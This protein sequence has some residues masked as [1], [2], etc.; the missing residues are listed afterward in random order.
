M[1][2]LNVEDAYCNIAVYPTHRFLLGMKWYGLYYVELVLPVNFNAVFEAVKWILLNCYMY[3]VSDLLH[4]LDDFIT[5][6]PP[7][8]PQCAQNLSTSLEVCKHLG[9][10]LHLEKCMRTFS[11][12]NMCWALVELPCPGCLPSF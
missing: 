7:Q 6:H 12:A 3:K 9:L 4:Y 5:A 8:S 1:A 11:C 2:K 10:P